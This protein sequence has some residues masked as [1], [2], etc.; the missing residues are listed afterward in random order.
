MTFQRNKVFDRERGKRSTLHFLRYLE[1]VKNTYNP[2]V[3]LLLY[4]YVRV[5]FHGIRYTSIIGTKE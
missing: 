2:K 3:V 5:R 4:T 1:R